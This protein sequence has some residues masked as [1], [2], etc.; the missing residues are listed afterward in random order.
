AAVIAA[1]FYLRLIVVMY[2]AA[3]S[4]AGVEP[5]PETGH[6]EAASATAAAAEPAGPIPVAVGAGVALAIAMGFT[7]VVGFLPSAVFD[8]ARHATLLRL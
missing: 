8:F 7:L 4:E 2:M 3:P 1:F 6:V 5:A